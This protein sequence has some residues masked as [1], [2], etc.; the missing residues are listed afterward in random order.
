L[1]SKRKTWTTIS[2]EES[3]AEGTR[4]NQLME[5]VA[6]LKKTVEKNE[7]QAA[8]NYSELQSKLDGI[9]PELLKTMEGSSSMGE[10]KFEQLL[11]K[12]SSLAQAVEV[13]K[14]PSQSTFVLGETSGAARGSAEFVPPLMLQ[15]GRGSDLVQ[16]PAFR[17]QQSLEIRS[18]EDQLLQAPRVPANQ[19]LPPPVGGDFQIGQFPLGPF[20]SL[21]QHQFTEHR[22][23]ED[24]FTGRSAFHTAPQYPFPPPQYE[25]PPRDKNSM[26]DYH[27]GD[28]G[29]ITT[30]SV[31]IDFPKFDGCDPV[32]WIYR[33]NKFFNFHRIPY[34]QMLMLAS[35]HMEGKALVWYQ[36]MDMAGALPNWEV[37]THALLERFGPTCYD[38]PMESLTRLKQVSSV[39][40]YKESFEAISNRLRG[41]SDY[42]KLSCFL[43]GLKDEIRL[44]V[45]MFNPP[46]LLAAYGLAKVQEEHVLLGRKSYRS[47]FNSGVPKP[48]I[49]PTTPLPIT[50]LKAAI[51]IQN[52]SQAQMEERRK[53]G[54]C[55]NCDA[56]WQYGHK[57]QN[58]KLFLLDTEELVEK[59][60]L[61]AHSE[62]EE[63]GLDLIDFNYADS[64]PKISLQAITGSAHPKT[65]RVL[66]RING[67]QLVILIDSGST[68]NFLD[69][70]LAMKARILLDKDCRIR[71]KVANGKEVISE[72]KCS[73]V[74]LQLEKLTFKVDAY[75]IILAGCDM[76]LGIQ[77]LITLGSIVWNFKNL[78][79]EFT[80]ANETFQLQGLVAPKL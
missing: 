37:F 62:L 63:Q 55:Y 6:A 18:S 24:R 33:A 47:V 23:A 4:M 75:V 70:N 52:V 57:C 51:P 66:G 32:G 38:D 39:E 11:E 25:L 19:G 21:H 14:L 67:Q 31:R 77:W 17:N 68:H 45:S 79:M 7:A 10:R 35:I 41:I 5:T 73:A 1:V 20:P 22:Q 15:T 58:P 44:P 34:N 29:G 54:L 12:V 69:T 72:G 53:K 49:T 27:G 26:Y 59:L 48:G 36:D 30:R 76:V 65:M 56:K 28:H 50:P 60:E 42:N 78:T 40:E 74:H 16:P 64:K 3:M 2:L 9:A 61:A 43:S 71:V 13:I 8:K 80:L 46:T